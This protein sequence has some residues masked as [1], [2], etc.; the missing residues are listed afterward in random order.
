ME[1]ELEEN[2]QE[3][4][5]KPKTILDRKIKGETKKETTSKPKKKKVKTFFEDLTK[6]E[7]CSGKSAMT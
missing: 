4:P 1:S 3:T 5:E 2:K 7:K 6:D